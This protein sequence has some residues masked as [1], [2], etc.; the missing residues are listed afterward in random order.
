MSNAST[1]LWDLFNEISLGQGQKPAII[2]SASG[3]SLSYAE[4]RHRAIEFSESLSSLPYKAIAIVGEPDLNLLPIFLSAAQLGISCVPLIDSGPNEML[5]EVLCALPVNCLVFSHRKLPGLKEEPK[6]TPKGLEF[7]TYVSSGTGSETRTAIP[8][9]V[10]HSSGSTGRP[11]PIAIRQETKIKRTQQSIRLFGVNSSDVIL[12]VSPLHHSL[13]QRHLFLALL[14]GATLVKTHP[15]RVDGWLKAVETYRPTL[16]IP[17][18]T[19]LKLLRPSLFSTPSLLDSF[20]IIVTSSAPA[21][22]E[23]KRQI[24]YRAGFAFWEIYG[25]TETAC[26]TA[27]LYSFGAN[28]DHLGSALPGT[29]IRI[30]GVGIGEI[31]V[32]SDCLCDGYWGDDERWAASFTSDGFFKSGDLGRLDEHGNLTYLGRVNESFQSAG[33]MVYPADIE[34]VVLQM[35][36][37]TDC[38][39]YPIPNAVFENVVGLV[40]ATVAN[41]KTQ[42]IAKHCRKKLPKHMWPVRIK[43]LCELP[44]LPSG[45][46]DRKMINGHF[47]RI[48]SE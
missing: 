7:F 45:K 22:P 25:M 21:E 2:E 28:T 36:Y 20:R 38:V 48:Q 17:V 8:Y 37:I 3:D 14:T 15:F 39:A 12:S 27:I 35:P 4:L 10:T 9:L 18:A 19:H 11:K 13:G 32:K 24:L 40:V 5:Q 23:F 29:E 46:T 42:E 6:Y 16:A 33:L 44:R 31:E 34:K 1:P 41:I 43:M 30:K 47:S 26:A